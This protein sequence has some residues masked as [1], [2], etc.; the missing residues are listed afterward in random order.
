M[1]KKG[2]DKESARHSMAKKFGKAPPYRKKKSVLT[3]PKMLPIVNLE[4]DEGT[5]GFKKGKYFFD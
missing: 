2:W 3:N 5:T 1:V 4:G